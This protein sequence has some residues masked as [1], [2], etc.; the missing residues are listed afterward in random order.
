M[1]FVG[2][3]ELVFAPDLEPSAILKAFNQR[4][5]QYFAVTLIR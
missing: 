1:D 5:F 4:G 2:E 3:L